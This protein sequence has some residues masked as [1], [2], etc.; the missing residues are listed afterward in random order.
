VKVKGHLEFDLDDPIE[1]EQFEVCSNGIDLWM[2][3]NTIRREVQE[4]H[5]ESAN[6]ERAVQVIETACEAYGFDPDALS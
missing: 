2:C 6:I 1:K 4:L 3:I 5:R